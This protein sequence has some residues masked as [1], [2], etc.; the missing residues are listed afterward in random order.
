MK[1]TKSGFTLVEVL[2]S[3]IVIAMMMVSIFAFV[4]YAGEVWQR[5]QFATTMSNEGQMILDTFDREMSFTTKIISPPIGAPATSTIIYKRTI[6]DYNRSYFTASC[7]FRIEK[8]PTE[9]RVYS[10]YNEGTIETGWTVADYPA[11][12]TKQLARSRHN[13]DLGRHVDTLEISRISANRVDIK[14]VLKA[15]RAEDEFET[16]NEYNRS[17]LIPNPG[18]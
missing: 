14:V 16:E 11:P 6:F 12:V 8:D 7:S 3:S 1:T 17:V 9:K 13:Y 5:T 15:K 4:S 10:K 2:V 18:L